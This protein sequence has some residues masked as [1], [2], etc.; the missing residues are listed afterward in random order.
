MAKKS[1]KQSA[2]QAAAINAS[3]KKNQSLFEIDPLASPEYQDGKLRS[4]LITEGP[5]SAAV[6]SKRK[7]T[8]KEYLLI[9]VLLVFAFAIR[10]SN[11]KSPNSVVFD[12]VHFGGFAR[13]YILGNFF[14]DVHPPLAKMLFAAV[15]L[16]FGFKGDF[17]FK[18]IGDVYPDTTPYYYMRALPA[19]LGVGTVLLCY[20]TLRSS[21]VRPAIAFITSSCLIIENSY[22]TISRYILLDS[23]LLF[24]IAA[25]IFSIKK[26]EIQIPFTLDWFRS[27]IA[28]GIALGLALSSKWVGLFTVAWVGLLCVY[29][30]WF[31]IGDLNVPAKKVFLHFL[32]RGAFLLGIPIFIY[33]LFFEVHFKLLVNEGDGSPFM[34]SAFRAGL[35]GNTIPT[36]I[37]ANVGYGSIVS[38]RHLNT[39]GGYLHSHNNFYPT[40]SK[41]Q[42]ITLYPHLDAN[43]NW[44]IEPYNAS[45]PDYFKPLKNG[46]KIRLVHVNTGR[47]LHSHDEKPPVSERD[48][49]KEASCYGYDGFGGDA[50][51]DFV[52]EILDYKSE[53]GIAQTE[54]KALK[55]IFRLKHAMTGNYLFS[56]EVKLPAWGFE[57]Q[58][59]TTASQG[60]R[61][62][63][64]WYIET[65]TNPY[66]NE[67]N[68]EYV[69]YPKLSLWDKFVESH[70]T[71]WKINQGLTEYHNWQSSPTDWPL[72][73]RGINYW[74]KDHRQVYFIGN[75][76][77]WWFSSIVIVI[78]GVHAFIS[79]IKWQTGKKIA[80]DKHVYNFNH[81]VF[82][83]ALG[84]FIH[85][86]P[87]Y[88]M[89]R[90]LFLH[91]YIPSA[92]FALLVIGH[93]F[94]VFV[95]Y[96]MGSNKVLKKVGYGTLG[97][98]FTL[99]LLFYINYSP[100]IDG[101]PWTKAQCENSKALS[102]W[103]FSCNS[104]YNSLEEYS[105]S[106]SATSTVQQTAVPVDNPGEYKEVKET[107]SHAEEKKVEIAPSPPKQEEEQP[108]HEENVAPPAAVDDGTV[109]AKE[110]D[111]ADLDETVKEAETVQAKVPAEEPVEVPAEQVEAPV[112]EPVAEPVV[113]AAE[114][115]VEEPEPVAAPVEEPVAIPEEKKTTHDAQAV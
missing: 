17:E 22:V 56:S 48:W 31:I 35:I 16:L 65:N 62:L 100:L 103:D 75:A 68:T 11:L 115:V 12:E 107:P 61:P 73:L 82:L 24:F 70:K 60:Y 92:Y 77:V 71:M 42:Q 96:L 34:S 95:N 93:T 2:V 47:R 104:F 72:L 27:L 67:T 43:N 106:P 63:T 113:A 97:V 52:V 84:W 32:F 7:T 9:A 29:Q 39:Q 38:I 26:F 102:Q 86:F 53:P 4:F 10:F 45:I 36:N 66:L 80:T 21:G 76:V 112:E 58:E 79:L 28:T 110:N 30:L 83:Y 98:F 5:S 94:D 19:L 20:L 69:N 51:D 90:Q 41:Q 14:M 64:H 50:N 109:K 114:P 55:S 59:V 78:F 40:G 3:K 54:V 15:G 37:N 81:Q 85:Y 8:S 49:Q 6:L 57:Q 23:P 46:D 108:K 91:H 74:A 13:K 111:P 25:A 89:G 1:G 101:S 44:K 18:N 88:I 87:F 99:S 105:L 33:I